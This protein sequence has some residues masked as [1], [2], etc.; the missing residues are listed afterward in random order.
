MEKYF[1]KEDN[2]DEDRSNRMAILLNIH[3]FK[4]IDKIINRQL[5]ILEL[6]DKLDD[7]R[8]IVINVYINPTYE[9]REPN[10]EI[11][12]NIKNSLK[13]PE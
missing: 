13:W 8:I 2:K 12:Q 7:Q 5:I 4:V 10:K 1:I 6:I 9:R 3:R 11:I